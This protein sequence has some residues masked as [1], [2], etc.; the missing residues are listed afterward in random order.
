MVSSSSLIIFGPSAGHHR[1]R[2]KSLRFLFP[3]C[4]HFYFFPSIYSA[5]KDS[6]NTPWQH[7]PPLWDQETFR[8]NLLSNYRYGFQN[9]PHLPFQLLGPPAIAIEN[10]FPGKKVS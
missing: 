10:S 9:S 6:L 7:T 5:F 3:L 2:I 8:T 1:A 4:S